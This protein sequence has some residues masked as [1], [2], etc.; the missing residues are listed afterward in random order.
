MASTATA[1]EGANVPATQ[2]GP[3]VLSAGVIAAYEAMIETVPESGGDGMDSILEAIAQAESP[4]DLDAPWR[5]AGL[6]DYIN[7]PLVIRAI[8]KVPSDYQGGLP[9]FLVADAVVVPTGELVT[10]TTGAVAPV[11]Q[12]VRA[13]HQG[14]LPWTVIPRQSDRASKSGY[15]PQHLEA[16]PA[17]RKS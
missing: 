11:A 17:A 4:D 1:P 10:I 15:Y 6:E 16:V 7:V 5:S 3:T 2:D 9:W 13:Y 8:R 14:W 12:L